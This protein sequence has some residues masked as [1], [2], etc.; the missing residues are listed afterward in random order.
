MKSIDYTLDPH[1]L[2]ALA[3]A[4]WRQHRSAEKILDRIKDAGELAMPSVERWRASSYGAR[5]QAMQWRR[6]ATLIEKAR[7]R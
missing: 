5:L 6:W 4:R 2:R 3:D 1:T 7:A